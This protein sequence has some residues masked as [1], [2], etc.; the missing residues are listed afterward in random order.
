MDLAAGGRLR[1]LVPILNSGGYR[2]QTDSSNPSEHTIVLSAKNLAGYEVSYY[3]IERH[4]HGQVQLKFQSAEM[5]K[6]GNTI[7]EGRA[8]RLPFPLPSKAEHIRLIYLIRNSQADHNM[9]IATS[10]NLDA[11]NSFTNQLKR[12]PDVCAPAGAV[13]CSWVPAGIAV[14]PE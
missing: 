7:Q 6:D 14:R 13:F 11:L 12:N 2:V 1:I 10:K 4:P 8:P 9:A 3:S 5:T